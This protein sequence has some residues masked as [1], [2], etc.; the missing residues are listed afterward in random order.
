MV[1]PQSRAR[2]T[3][4]NPLVIGIVTLSGGD[5]KKY[6]MSQDRIFGQ[7]NPHIFYNVDSEGKRTLFNRDF[8]YMRER[9]LREQSKKEQ[10]KRFLSGEHSPPT[11]WNGIIGDLISGSADM[12][13]A[14][15][16]VSK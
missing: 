11:K 2:T 10:G 13:F 3:D 9:R 1:S 4:L 8:S 5:D 7:K 6:Y 15:L 14:A 16:S 12:S